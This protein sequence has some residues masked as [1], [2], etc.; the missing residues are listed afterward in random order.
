MTYKLTNAINAGHKFS[1]TLSILH[2]IDTKFIPTGSELKIDDNG[3]TSYTNNIDHEVHLGVKGI[4]NMWSN[5]INSDSDFYSAIEYVRTHELC[6]LL[7]TGGK[8]YAWAVN[9]G[10]RKFCEYIASQEKDTVRFRKEIDLENYIAT[11]NE[12]YKFNV[13]NFLGEISSFIANSL[14]DG[15][16]ERI[17]AS[18]NTGF[19][20]SRTYYRGVCNWNSAKCEPIDLDNPIESLNLILNQILSLATCQVYQKGYTSLYGTKDVYKQ[21]NS[22][23]PNISK[24]YLAKNTHD[25]A[26]ASMEICE[27]LSPLVY[28]SIQSIPAQQDDMYKKLLEE[29]LKK[30][31]TKLAESDDF[32]STD[33]QAA[34]DENG[35]MNSIFGQSDLK[36][37]LPDAVYDK[38][39]EK[40]KESKKSGN[41][42]GGI[43]ILREHPKEE[44]EQNGEASKAQSESSTNQQGN[45]Q[46]DSQ[47]QD[48]NK[49]S[50]GS[51]ESADSQ[52]QNNSS[53][54]TEKFDSAKQLGDDEK[55]S[56]NGG[57][58]GASAD[59]LNSEQIEAAMKDAAEK[60]HA[61][62]EEAVSSINQASTLANTAKKNFKEVDDNEK[63]L[64]PE[65]A[66]KL[67][68]N[69]RE[70]TRKYKLTEKLPPDLSQRG[71]VLHTKI[72]RYFK[73]LMSPNIKGR[74]TGMLDRTAL[75]RLAKNKTNIFMK[76]G[77]SKQVEGCVYILLDNSGS[78]CGLKKK[79]ACRAAAVIEEGFKG[80]MPMKIVAFDSSSTIN[81]EIIKNWNEVKQ[82]NCCWNYYKKSRGG[83]GNDDQYDIR[84]ATAELLKRPESRKMLIVLS[85]GAPSNTY[86]TREEIRKARR[87]GI[88]V[89]G[90][91]FEEG[92]IGYDA[93]DFRKMYERDY[94]CCTTDQIYSELEKV[95]QKFA[96]G[97]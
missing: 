70:Y 41:Q 37:V 47:A 93:D 25:M 28:E 49:T 59:S 97:K 77:K 27:Q 40:S 46:S 32:G 39:Q 35:E 88:Q 84:I 76:K 50:E 75:T 91:Y 68:S 31:F 6:H 71:S 94:V 9:G 57:S 26:V 15:R 12:R 85:D 83:L 56:K 69:Y 66:R 74:K 82:Q 13:G 36:V 92:S 60:L 42:N 10:I 7:Y 18:Q 5:Y 72:E 90:I 53:N 65:E 21:T 34:E 44:K 67:C 55:K 95:L 87:K 64:T 19:S 89:S 62:S 33:S 61:E 58:S 2:S 73:S 48:N 4:M 86:A 11:L 80:L 52:K 78:M 24:G 63:T 16:I 45:S 20:K 14:E 81:H 3:D 1:S 30:L 17:Y 23:I 8:S 54:E 38:L 96:H 29:L 79:E 22:L 43:Q 51:N